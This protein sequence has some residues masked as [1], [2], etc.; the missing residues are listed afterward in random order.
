M[1]SPFQNI[2]IDKNGTG[3]LMNGMAWNPFTPTSQTYIIDG[4]GLVTRG[5]V[6]NAAAIWFNLFNPASVVWSGS[7]AC[8]DNC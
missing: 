8:T 2:A 7:S 1:A 6:W 3:L 4:V 5:F